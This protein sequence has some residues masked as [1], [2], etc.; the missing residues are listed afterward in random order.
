MT[1][2]FELLLLLYNLLRLHDLCHPRA[3]CIDTPSVQN[4]RLSFPLDLSQLR[5]QSN[6]KSRRVNKTS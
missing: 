4:P 6:S 2:G 1:D 5:L 3:S